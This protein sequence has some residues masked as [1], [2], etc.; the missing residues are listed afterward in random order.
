MNLNGLTLL[1]TQKETG[2]TSETI[3]GD[4]LLFPGS[5]VVITDIPSDVQTRYVSGPNATFLANDLPTLD[6]K[7]G[8]IT[9]RNGDGYNRFL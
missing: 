4:F 5:Y 7:S 8:N 1:N 2:K 3:E 6:A 9:I